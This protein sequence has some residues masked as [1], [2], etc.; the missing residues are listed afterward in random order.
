MTVLVKL[1]VE[2]DSVNPPLIPGG[3]GEAAIS[4]F[5]AEWLERAGLDVSLQPVAPGRSNVIAIARGS[6]AA[7]APCC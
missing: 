2:I 3:A 6:G 4:R 5:V 7:D 1:L